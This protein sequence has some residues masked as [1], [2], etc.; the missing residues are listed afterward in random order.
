MFTD[1]LVVLYVED[2]EKSLKLYRDVFGMTETYRF[3]QQ[4]APEH[5]EVRLGD[6]IL[7]ISSPSG[8]VSHG[9]PAV[10]RGGQPFE[11]A[12]GT[13]DVDAALE[14][15]RAAGC[16]IVREPFDSAAGNRVAYL[17]D[18]DGNRISIFAKIR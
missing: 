13:A 12:I 2:I 15:L 1:V 5:V 10:T 11:L 7:G 18:F 9:M 14:K 4:G 6:S 17:E 16:R 3:P 8:L